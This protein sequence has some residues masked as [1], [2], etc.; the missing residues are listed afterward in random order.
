M[1]NDI[2]SIGLTGLTAAQLGMATTSNNISNASTPGYSVEN[3]VF[4]ESSGQET[5][6]GYFGSGVTTATVARSYSQYLTTEL[7]N[8]QQTSS[9][10]TTNYSLTAQLNNL[11]GSPT[12]GIS[13]AITAY[14]SGLQNVANNPSDLATRQTAISN[15]Q[16]LA[17]QINAAGEQ[18][19][20]LRQS[21][22]Q[23]LSSA[24]GQINAFASQIAT[25]NTEI[26]S[27]SA[28]GQAPNQLLDQ[29]DQLVS[30]LSQVVGVSVVQNSSGYSLFMS[31]GQ[32][33]VVA[34]QAFQLGT[35]TSAGDPSELAVTYNGVAGS[36]APAATEY[37][38]SSALSGGTVGGLL[39]FRS[40]TLDP[41]QSQL[42]AIATSFASQVNGQN[43]L[44]LDLSG[45]PGGK[46]FNVAAPA[47]YAN[48]QNTGGA[49]LTASFANA[50]QPTADDYALSY[51]GAK[52]TLTDTTT[53]TV[54]GTATSIATTSPGTT[55]GGLALQM[56]SGNMNPG[57][58]FTIQ[59]TR[60][61][62]DSFA[63]ATTNPAAIAAAS[64][65][66]ASA[67]STNAGTATIT[68]GT[69]TAGYNIPGAPTTLTYASAT[70][71]LSGWPVGSTVSVN[72]GAPTTIAAGTTIPYASGDT[73]T[74]NTTPPA[75]GPNAISF[76]ISG[77]PAN[78]DTFKIQK[79]TGTNDGRNAIAMAQLVSNPALSN[80]TSTLTQAYSS[81]VN[82]VGNAATNLNSANTSQTT[83]VSQITSAQQSVSGVNLDEE[84]SN[85][86]KYQQLYQANSKVIQTAESLFQTLI[87]V[88]Q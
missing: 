79:N 20:Q 31:N 45:N 51:D 28:Q 12:A 72:G 80:G 70:G 78:G 56:P 7:N 2:F 64:P 61:A 36:A 86:M 54:V 41:A 50:A 17:A 11:I 1:S 32:P 63:L 23:Q 13:S 76:T 16:S 5:A 84:A 38:S 27:G 83:L 4:A 62:L 82:S 6:S 47:V 77:T 21:V 60:G 73:Y 14:F 39:A 52:Y 59:P 74:I 8:A 43:A 26:A 33:L 3:A 15:A 65:V 67:T 49:T 22:N 85:L 81:Y 29:R 9:S 35:A 66:L 46:L 44:G 24:V 40:Q 68:Q 10:L 34:N 53:G 25:L 19:D 37:L 75:A 58:S 57:D 42:G 18:Y 87:G 88:I 71:T 30:Q 55:I 48:Q 69:V